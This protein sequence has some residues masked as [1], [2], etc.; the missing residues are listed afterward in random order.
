MKIAIVTP[1]FN[2]VKLLERLFKSL[3]DQGYNNFTWVIIDDGSTDETE[4]YISNLESNFEIHYI[5]QNNGGK[6]RALNTA[7]N[8]SRHFDIYIIVDSDDYLLPNAIKKIENKAL[9]YE[10]NESVGAIFFRYQFSDGQLLTRKKTNNTDELVMTRAEYD[11]KYEKTDGCIVYYGKVIESYRYPEFAGEKYVGPTVL[12]MMMSE[13]FKIVFTQEVV[14][15]AEY[16]E[17][18]LTRSGRLLRIKN[19]IGM[20]VYC[21]YMQDKEFNKVTRVKYGIMANAYFYIG[22]KENINFE[23]TIPSDLKIPRI[24]RIFGDILGKYWVW[25]YN[26]VN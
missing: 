15:V 2:R 4:Q 3:I 13:R 5:K 11:N 25:R 14:G 24:Y 19:P 1:T 12:Q 21:H 23:K 16:Q 26:L 17:E 10:N 7:F 20:L 18:G 9:E 8:L 6:S 22:K